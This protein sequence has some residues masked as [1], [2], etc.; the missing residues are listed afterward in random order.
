MA[1]LSF[2]DRL[3]SPRGARAVTSPLGIV[4]VAA[5]VAA[6]WLVGLPWWL[7]IVL[8]AVAWSVFVWRRLPRAPRPERIDPFT[9][10]EPWRR[11]VQEAV[12]A[13]NRFDRA[14]DR[15]PA[16]PLR[17]RLSEIAARVR[18][19][20]DECWRIANQGE[21]LVEARRGIDVATVDRRLTQARSAA[22][23]DESA[24]GT[25][26]SL[27]VQKA[28]A[29]RLDRVI[30]RARSQLRLLDAR[31]DEAVARTLELSAHGAVEGTGPGAAGL[32]ADVD[33]VVTEMEALRLALEETSG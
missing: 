14:V 29:E 4:L 6:A 27:E 24:A 10:H 18:T 11:F 31:L 32:G 2:R 9:L 17:D 15:T 20:V 33:G 3:L 7:A 13:S 25:V 23:G 5:V 12:Q 19:G 21:A 28:T 8:G 1:A 22:P 26:A 30:D 16:G